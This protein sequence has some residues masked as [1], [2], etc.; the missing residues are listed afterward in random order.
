MNKTR[1][2]AV[3][4]RQPIKPQL[5]Q[6]AR[7]ALLDAL[8]P[9]SRERS[10]QMPPL[11]VEA[12]TTPTAPRHLAAAQGGNAAT[13]EQQAAS[14]DTC[15]RTYRDIARAQDGA[16]DADDVGAVMAFFVAINL[17]ALHGADIEAQALQPLER[18]LRGLTRLAAQWDIAT[19]AQRQFFFE[20]IA[21]VSILMS[22]SL[23]DA[24]G[25]P[26]AMADVRRSAREYLQHVLGLNPDLVTLSDSG[27]VLRD[28]AGGRAATAT[29]VHA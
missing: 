2:I 4:G 25:A 10:A 18:Q 20:R 14:Y 22:R 8:Q 15:L 13:R 12:A 9:G 7:K 5:S 19:L 11:R 29:P 21:I 28:M 23:A 6:L 24:R 27:L 26:A 1:S 16:P 17:H 3:A